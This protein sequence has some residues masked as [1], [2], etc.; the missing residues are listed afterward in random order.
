MGVVFL[1]YFGVCGVFCSVAGRGLSSPAG[2]RKRLLKQSLELSNFR[3]CGPA[4]VGFVCP[5][6]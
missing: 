3:N 1:A 2:L 5:T 4:V 6:C